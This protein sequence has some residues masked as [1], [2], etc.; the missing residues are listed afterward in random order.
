VILSPVLS[1]AAAPLGYVGPG[2][3]QAVLIERLTKYV[4][5]TPLNNVAGNPAMSV[6]LAWTADGLP[7]GLHFAADVGQERTLLE[8]AYQLEAA[9]PW[10]GKR[11]GVHA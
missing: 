7:I 8:L 3:D 2:V 4:G 9:R 10:A 6:P 5:Y 11:P 1:T